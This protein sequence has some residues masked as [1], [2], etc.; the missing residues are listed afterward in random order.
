MK[1]TELVDKI[2]NE[3]FD[4]EKE[5]EVKKYLPIEA[6]KTIAQAIIYECTNEESGAL[7]VDSVQQYLSYI[8]Y[9]IVT[10]TNL[11]YTED[12]YDTLCSTECGDNTL[13]N[14]I[15]GCFSDDAKECTRI[16]KLMTG[17]YTQNYSIEATLSK[18]LYQVG[19]TLGGLAS[20]VNNK[21]KDVN[22]ESL[23]NSKDISSFKNFFANHKF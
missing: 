2:N 12:D 7:V 13:L 10:H 17:D 15:I 22:L 20:S 19:D 9:M 14:V 4:L 11:E 18:F 16:L 3:E 21:V 6:K 8:R 5:L 23:V 1:V